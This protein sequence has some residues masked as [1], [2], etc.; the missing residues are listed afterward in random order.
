V[1]KQTADDS[2][3]DALIINAYAKPAR[4]LYP[5]LQKN[6]TATQ[7]PVYATSQIYLGDADAARDKNLDG[8]I[9]CDVPWI[10]SQVSDGELSKSALHD[11]WQDLSPSY[12]RLLPMGIDAYNLIGH[13]SQLK[14]QPFSGATGKLKLDG[15]NRIT[16]EL[17]CAK[18][19][20]G[21]PKITDAANE[22][23]DASPLVNQPDSVIT[24][25]KKI[26][27]ALPELPELDDSLNSQPMM[28][29]P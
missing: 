19:V 14:N 17:Q 11:S 24:A 22:N 23:S 25:N 21:V 20:N 7:L 1:F 26:K 16:R 8:V 10:F 3:V 2:A 4:S 13:L 6:K 18:F 15:D 12:L 28:L 9:F 5:Q 29:Q 27:P